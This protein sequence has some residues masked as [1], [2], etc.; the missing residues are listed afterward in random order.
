MT[1]YLYKGPVMEYGRCISN[2]WEGSTMAPSESKARN[3]LAYQFKKKNNR[4]AGSKIVLPGELVA[5]G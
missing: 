4:V 2:C 1:K 3:N 5:V